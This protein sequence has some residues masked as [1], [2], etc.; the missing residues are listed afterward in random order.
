MGLGLPRLR[1]RGGEKLTVLVEKFST[2]SPIV[3]EINGG[4]EKII[5]RIDINRTRYTP[6]TRNVSA[7]ITALIMAQDAR[8][9]Y[10]LKN[11]EITMYAG[12]TSYPLT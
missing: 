6:R 12:R 8:G 11:N 5:T 9:N 2:G 7:D 3:L 10:L 1:Q 4:E